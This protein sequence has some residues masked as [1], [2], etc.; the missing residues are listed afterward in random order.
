MTS[1]RNQ[2]KDTRGNI[3]DAGLWRHNAVL[4]FGLTGAFLL[5]GC[6][7]ARSSKHPSDNPCGPHGE[8]W[9]NTYPVIAQT[10]ESD[11][12]VVDWIP[13]PPFE[14]PVLPGTDAGITQERPWPEY[15]HQ[16][17]H[18]TQPYPHP[19]ELMCTCDDGYVGYQGQPCT[20]RVRNCSVEGEGATAK[21]QT[22]CCPDLTLISQS[23][24]I[25]G[26]CVDIA[27]DLG[28]CT[29]CGNGVCGKGESHC[30]C[31]ADCPNAPDLSQLK[32]IRGPGGTMEDAK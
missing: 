7:L 24:M 17:P 3:L 32:I 8:P 5:V 16:G 4:R 2:S 14:M 30:N 23:K 25:D 15:E 12:T 22:Y 26:Q 28:I 13:G 21:T 20:K 19:K 10:V 1:E 9:K 27:P 6:V 29:Q 31:P 18:G 11:G